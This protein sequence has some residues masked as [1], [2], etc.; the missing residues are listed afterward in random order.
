MLDSYEILTRYEKK[1]SWKKRFGVIYRFYLEKLLII[2]FKKKISWIF[3][4]LIILPII[5]GPIVALLT[6]SLDQVNYF[7]L[8]SD[9]MFLGYIGIFIPLFTLYF[10][11]MLSHDEIN[12]G[13][14]GYITTRPIHKIELV[15][16]K[17]LSF[18][19]IIPLFTAI[20]GVLFYLPFAIFGG[21]IYYKAALMFLLGTVISTIVYGAFY[22]YIGV[23]FKNPLWFG[24]FFSLIW[25]FVIVSFSATVNNFTIAYY[26]KSLLVKGNSSPIII[27][28]NQ[29]YEFYSLYGGGASFLNVGLVLSLV[30]IVSLTLTWFK[31][32]AYKIRLPFQIG[33][34]LGDWKHHLKDIRSVLLTFGIIIISVGLVIGPSKGIKETSNYTREVQIDISRRYFYGNENFRP[35]IEDMGYG[36]YFS[37]SLKKSDSLVINFEPINILTYN[38]SYWGLVLTKIDF[39]LFF[40]KTQELWL[41]YYEQV[42]YNYD[43]QNTYSSALLNNYFIEVNSLVDK[44]LTKVRI[45]STTI[46]QKINYTATTLDD[47]Y[48]VYVLGGYNYS[49]RLYFSDTYNIILTRISSRIVLY[50]LGWLF[51]SVGFISIGFV[52]YLFIIESKK[53]ENKHL[54]ENKELPITITEEEAESRLERK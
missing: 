34:G 40:N 3:N 41:D 46:D 37:Y 1:I 8:Y 52:I 28:Q 30:V 13:T 23:L 35:S 49:Q 50:T 36:N 14:I 9:I 4:S 16:T 47:Y 17:Y 51:F 20:S 27:G 24:L 53:V 45:S 38:T 25:E 18:L 39:E 5:V 10:A 32:Q 31:L 42:F 6:N 44:A 48:I 22:L 54:V 29:A 43:S 7:G 12:D 15:I 33:K 2:L 11:S 21:F 19:T 26:I